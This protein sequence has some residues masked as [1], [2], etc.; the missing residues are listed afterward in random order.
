MD[1]VHYVC[2]FANHF[3]ED[4]FIG[5]E[6]GEP[7]VVQAETQHWIPISV[8][9]FAKSKD[10]AMTRIKQGLETIAKLQE[11]SDEYESFKRAQ[12]ILDVC[13]FSVCEFDKR[14]LGKAFWAGNE[15]L[16]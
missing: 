5:D 1:K 7:F 16:G 2:P 11:E 8:I 12:E 4:T 6:N 13:E 3:K 9:I 10:D 15:Y 14:K